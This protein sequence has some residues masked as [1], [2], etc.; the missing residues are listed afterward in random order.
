VV[1]IDE[2]MAVLMRGVEYGDANIQ[3]TMEHDLRERLKLGRPLRVYQGFD[4]TFTGL[5]L[6]NVVGM[7]KLR[8]FQRFGHE[9]TFLIGTMTARIGDPTDKAAARQ[10]LTLEDVEANARSWL[11][12]ATAFSTRSRRKSRATAIG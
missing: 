12:Q 7:L 2:Q 4:P 10:Q 3:R 5:T 6:G 1:S 9:V 11:D 8:Q